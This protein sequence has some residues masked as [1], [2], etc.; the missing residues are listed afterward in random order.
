MPLPYLII[1]LKFYRKSLSVPADVV[2]QQ[3][4][5]RS[6]I[7]L[8]CRDVKVYVIIIRI[9]PD[10]RSILQLAFTAGSSYNVMSTL[11]SLLIGHMCIYSKNSK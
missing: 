5:V 2:V 7:Q 9:E 10:V 4:L 1:G 3:R 11:S 8:E 6:S